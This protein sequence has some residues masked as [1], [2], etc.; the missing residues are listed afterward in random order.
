MPGESLGH[1]E[2][3]DS[4]QGLVSCRLGLW[5][6]GGAVP[7]RLFLNTGLENFEISLSSALSEY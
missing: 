1:A 5:A 2:R 7:G 4:S 3:R 6:Y